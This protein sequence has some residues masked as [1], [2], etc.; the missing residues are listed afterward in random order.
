MRAGGIAGD[1]F[2]QRLDSQTII[3]HVARRFSPQVDAVFLNVN[4]NPRLLPKMSIPTVA[5]I[6]SSHGGPLVGLQT[7]LEYTSDFQFLASVTADNPFLPIDLVAKLYERQQKTDASIVLASSNKRMHPIFGLWKTE[8]LK[9]LI[10][11]LARS[12]KASVFAFARHIGLEQVEFPLVETAHGASYDPFFNI[13]DPDD[14][15]EA[16][17]LN[18]AMK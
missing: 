5:D 11:W 10:D 6:E 8:L 1:K 2:L 12:E 13:N 16:R 14:L 3:E 18:E 7:A 9:P 17:Q 4:C 15:A